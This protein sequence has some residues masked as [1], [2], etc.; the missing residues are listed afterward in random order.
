MFFKISYRRTLN[1]RMNMEK[2]KKN[3]DACDGA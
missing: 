3:K 1:P 2:V